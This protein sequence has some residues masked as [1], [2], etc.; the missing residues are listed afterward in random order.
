[1]LHKQGELIAYALEMEALGEPDRARGAWEYVALT[2]N[3]KAIDPNWRRRPATLDRVRGTK[4]TPPRKRAER[5]SH[6]KAILK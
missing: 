1:V 6:P 4:P 5:T 3:T 2:L